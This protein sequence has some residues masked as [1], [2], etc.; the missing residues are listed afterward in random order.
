VEHRKIQIHNARDIQRSRSTMQGTSKDP[1]SQ[2]KGCQSRMRRLQSCSGDTPLAD[3][4]LTWPSRSPGPSCNSISQ[5]FRTGRP[6]PIRGVDPSTIRGGLTAEWASVPIKD[7]QMTGTSRGA[8]LQVYRRY[9]CTQPKS[10]GCSSSSPIPQQ[11]K[12]ANRK[13]EVRRHQHH[14]QWSLLQSV[15][16]RTWRKSQSYHER[17][18][19]L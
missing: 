2:C 11:H 14:Q 12:M 8:T 9:L 7:A 4:T 3:V 6:C 13:M 1:D 15:A 10:S 18:R 5:Q 16:N 17:E 19:F